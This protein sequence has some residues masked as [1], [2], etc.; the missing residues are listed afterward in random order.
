MATFSQSTMAKGSDSVIDFCCSPCL[1]HKTDQWAEF[2]CENCLKFYCANCINLHGQLFGKH[3]TY[4]R[5]E[6]KK[7]PV[8]K[9]VEDFLQKCDLHEEKRSELFCY[10]H[11]QLCCTDCSFLNHRQ[12]VKV[13]LI[14]ESVNGPPPDLQRLSRKIQ[15]ILVEL[16]RLTINWDTNMQSL[17]VSYNEELHELRQTRKKINTLFDEIEK[18]TLKELDDKMTRLKAS[19]NNDMENCNKLK[20]ELNRLSNA[21]ENIIDKG[22]AE[23]I[24][25]ASKKCLQ[26]IKESET[27]LNENSVQVERILAFQANSDVQQYLSKLSNLGRFVVCTQSVPVQGDPCEL[28][29]VHGMSK[30][31]T[32]LN[33]VTRAYLYF[34]ISRNGGGTL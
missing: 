1:E 13:T 21:I 5:R 11:S 20:N 33:P 17:Q 22:K 14:S 29:T 25:I 32:T 27:Y 6:T 10:D 24:F 15:T 26:K 23:L 9:E 19:L 16:Q 4:G 7:W 30:C 8:P 31:F 3:V 18:N 2:Y 28:L 34:K 12:C